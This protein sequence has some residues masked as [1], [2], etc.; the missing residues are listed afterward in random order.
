MLFSPVCNA[1]V[2]SESAVIHC[3]PYVRALQMP[4]RR[5]TDAVFMNDRVCRCVYRLPPKEPGPA[6]L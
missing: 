1:T 6:A 3:L 4:Q 2:K 5:D